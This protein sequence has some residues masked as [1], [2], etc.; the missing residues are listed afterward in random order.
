MA[1]PTTRE[2]FKAYCLR[3]L[4]APVITINLDDDQIE[5]RIDEALQTYWDYHFDGVEKT[6]FKYQI[7]EETKTNRY[8]PVPENIIGVVNIFPISQTLNSSNM[9]NIRY[10]IA[11]N[12]LYTL[13]S[14]S[15]VPYYMAF[16]HIQ[17]L[18]Q[19]LV[20]QQPIRYNRHVNKLYIDMNWDIV[21][22]GD[23]M[24]AEAYQVVDPEVYSDVWKDRW[25]LRF[26]T[27]LIKK[28]WGQSTKKF[29]NMQLP[30]GLAF[31]GQQIYDE[32][33]QEEKEL[34]EEL[35]NSWSLSSVDMI[36]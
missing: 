21:N 36:G 24:I 23:F 31:N 19:I 9:F 1:L 29:Q 16:Q 4:G 13:T 2:E 30:G 34:M 6:Y 15:M 32:A 27:C 22:V 18:E 35:I 33:I 28:N 14:V 12:D 5:D 7:T 25:L 26:A 17:F 11:L 8:L 20:G 3:A 10:Q